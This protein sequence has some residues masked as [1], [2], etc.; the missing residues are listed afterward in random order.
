M[1]N[2]LNLALIS[3]ITLSSCQ[4]VKEVA[5]DSKKEDVGTNS[6]VSNKLTAVYWQQN[7]AEYEALC[8]Q[9]FN[10]AQLYLNQL[11][12]GFD[13]EGNYISNLQNDTKQA[14]IMDIDETI[15]NN[16][17]YNG[18]LIKNQTNFSYNSWIDWTSMASAELIPGALEFINNTTKAGIEIF[19]LSNRTEQELDFTIQN[20]R[21]K[22]VQ[23]KEENILLGRSGL[24]SEKIA[25]RNS[26]SP[27]YDIIMLIGD[28]LADFHDV[29]ESDIM[30][31]QRKEIVESF[32]NE[33]GKKFIILPNVMYGGWEPVEPSNDPSIR[34]PLKDIDQYIESFE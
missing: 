34:E 31:S 4:A 10:A 28:N 33:F 22:G 1:K 29:F 2:L 5:E 19:F 7:S 26:I 17:P 24:N 9:A 12:D 15:L 30:L 3:I 6:L 27:A 14:I 13:A 11:I 25:R 21:E 16:S 18:Y 20:L 32:Q 23:F 8:Y